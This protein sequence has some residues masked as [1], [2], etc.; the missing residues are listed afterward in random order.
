MEAIRTLAEYTTKLETKHNTNFTSSQHT[1]RAIG[2][3]LSV[4][5]IARQA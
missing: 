4:L 3:T 1:K 5:L 2:G